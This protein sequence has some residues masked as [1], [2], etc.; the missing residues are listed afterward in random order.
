[1]GPVFERVCSDAYV[2]FSERRIDFQ[3]ALELGAVPLKGFM[4]R[5]TRQSDL[6]FAELVVHPH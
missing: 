3:Q 2:P 5:Q 4:L 1:M 6:A